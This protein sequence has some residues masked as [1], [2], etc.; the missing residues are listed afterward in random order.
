MDVLSVIQTM[1]GIIKTLW[2]VSQRVKDNKEG[3]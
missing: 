3:P 1:A 2:E